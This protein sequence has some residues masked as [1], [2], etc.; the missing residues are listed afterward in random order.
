MPHK[1]TPMVY[2][3]RKCMHAIQPFKGRL[4]KHI[5]THAQTHLKYCFVSQHLEYKFYRVNKDVSGWRG[6]RRCLGLTVGRMGCQ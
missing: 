3:Y 5:Q 2:S 4:S 6:W 1:Q